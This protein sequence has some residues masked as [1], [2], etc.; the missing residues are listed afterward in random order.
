[1]QRRRHDKA[2]PAEERPVPNEPEAPIGTAEVQAAVSEAVQEYLAASLP[3]A[4]PKPAPPQPARAVPPAEPLAAAP[5][6]IR[7]VPPMPK[8]GQSGASGFKDSLMHQTAMPRLAEQ[9]GG[10]HRL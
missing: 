10:A 5:A 6:A 7:Y 1:M 8:A 9:G 2:N 4:A 3:A